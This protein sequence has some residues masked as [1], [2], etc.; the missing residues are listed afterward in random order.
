MFKILFFIA[1]ILIMSAFLLYSDKAKSP[2]LQ[3]SEP[4]ITG[5]IFEVDESEDIKG[6]G[7]SGQNKVVSNSKNQLFVTY[8]KKVNEKYSIFVARLILKDGA[9]QI[10]KSINVSEQ[11]ENLPSQRVGS[12]LID[13]KDNIHLV[14]YGEDKNGDSGRQIKY[15]KSE[16]DGETW[17]EP[18]II[19]LVEGFNKENLWQEHP[20]VAADRDGVVYVSWEGKDKTHPNQQI[21]FSKSSDGKSWSNW[22]NILPGPSSQS[23][24]NILVNSN[25]G[26]FILAYSR[27]GLE[28]QQIWLSKSADQGESWSEWQKI[29]NSETDS[30]HTDAV[31][32]SSDNLHIV[33]RQETPASK[34]QIY[35]S[36]FNG[37]ES[38]QPVPVSFEETYQLFPQIGLGE[39]NQIFVT[40]LQTNQKSSFPEDDPE[41]GDSYL[42][43][44][45]LSQK[46]FNPKKLVSQNSVYPNILLNSFLPSQTIVIFSELKGSSFPVKAKITD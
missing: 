17:T 45:D 11:S 35:Y 13:F 41:T 27:N 7:Y 9:L 26:L 4:V 2:S 40:W 30:R 43:F 38:S 19:S 46:D 14:W 33:W 12:L 24:P 3:K 15:A 28:N 36:I 31:M 32:D 5:Q 29:S 16:D 39:N 34:A 25:G 18:V 42:S 22:K 21:K 23:R 20:S 1:A 37:E 8:R 44:K 6:L 10:E